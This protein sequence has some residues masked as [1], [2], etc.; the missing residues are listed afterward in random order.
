MSCIKAA[1]TVVQYFCAW[2]G[3]SV[4]QCCLLA[5]LSDV[6]GKAAF[7]RPCAE[8]R[9]SVSSAWAHGAFGPLPVGQERATAAVT[10]R[11]DLCDRASRCA[12]SATRVH[13][14]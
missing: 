9:L 8:V 2:K 6:W 14:V 13:R 1:I 10:R 4:L 11:A 7:W 3:V 5:Y 12:G